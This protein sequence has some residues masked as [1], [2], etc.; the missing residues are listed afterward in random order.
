MR[1]EKIEFTLLVKSN[2]PYHKSIYLK[3]KIIWPQSFTDTTV[4]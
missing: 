2:L 4:V 1:I 3:G